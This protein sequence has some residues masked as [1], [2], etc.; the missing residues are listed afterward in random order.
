MVTTTTIGYGDIVPKTFAGRCIG[1]GLMVAGISLAG[2][3]IGIVSQFMQQ[4]LGSSK[5]HQELLQLK[6]KLAEEKALTKRLTDALERDNELK[7]KLLELMSKQTA[8]EEK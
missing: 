7:S 2:A 6:A 1:M 3:F 8:K 5:E 4:R